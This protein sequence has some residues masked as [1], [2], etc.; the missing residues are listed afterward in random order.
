MNTITL[1]E[2][3]KMCNKNGITDTKEIN[4]RYERASR[5]SKE[6]SERVTNIIMDKLKET[7]EE[8][9]GVDKE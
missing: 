5:I 4:E 6:I 8:L 1:E 7:I 9:K 3:T 2:F